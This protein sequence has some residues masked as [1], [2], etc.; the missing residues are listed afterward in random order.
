MNY[1]YILECADKTLYTGWT[2]NLASRIATHNAGKGS[3]Y[4]RS[5]LP[6]KLVYHESY[7][8]KQEAMRREYQI[9]Q[10]SRSEKLQLICNAKE[11]NNE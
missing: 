3:K 5:R 6:A 9:K 8:T 2:N 7:A 11:L 1:V 4:V 10:L